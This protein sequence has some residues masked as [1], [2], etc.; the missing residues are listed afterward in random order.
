LQGAH[1]PLDVVTVTGV[2]FLPEDECI[3]GRNRVHELVAA[4]HARLSM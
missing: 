3:I 1:A 4:L 2:H